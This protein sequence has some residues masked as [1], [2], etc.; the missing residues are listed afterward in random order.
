MS[1]ELNAVALMNTMRILAG[2]LVEVDLA[3]KKFV[4]RVEVVEGSFVELNLIDAKIEYLIEAVAKAAYAK[5]KF[6]QLTNSR[7][8]NRQAFEKIVGDL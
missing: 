2:N 1:E 8:A 3:K 6:D 5:G 7:I 4:V